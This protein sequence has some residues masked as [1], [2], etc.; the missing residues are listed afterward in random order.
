MRRWRRPGLVVGSGV[1]LVLGHALWARCL[2]DHGVAGA[3]LAG[4][5]E[6]TTVVAAAGFLLFRLAGF[7]AL[8]A[9]P[10]VLV[11]RWTARP[12]R[13]EPPRVG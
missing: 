2:V 13:F 3:L 5:G 12:E 1:V 7:V 10:A 11:W 8:A 4:G 6:W 9:V